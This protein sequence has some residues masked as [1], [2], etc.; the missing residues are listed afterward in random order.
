MNTYV[1][2]REKAK[3]ELL[4]LAF[5][6]RAVKILH[7]FNMSTTKCRFHCSK[8]KTFF[9]CENMFKHHFCDQGIVSFKCECGYKTEMKSRMHTHLYNHTRRGRAFKC[10]QCGTKHAS[11]EKLIAHQAKH[12]NAK[13]H[14]PH[15][16]EYCD[17]SYG[18]RQRLQFHSLSNSHIVN[19]V[20]S[21]ENESS[22][23]N[24]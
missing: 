12:M 5:K 21:L 3:C 19:V 11:V 10:E 17:K 24:N 18:T 6:N 22:D 7:S 23:S 2:W 8:C 4:E 9:Y 15:Y 14:T 16:C 1:S 20:L 13:K